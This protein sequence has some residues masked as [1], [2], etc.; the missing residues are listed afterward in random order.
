MLKR[1]KLSLA[2][3]TYPVWTYDENDMII[4]NDLPAEWSNDKQLDNAFMDISDMYDLQFIDNAV[5]FEY[6]GF[7][8][9]SLRESFISK[10]QKAVEMIKKKN[11]NKYVIQNNI[12]ISS[13]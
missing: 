9:D 2:Y 11:N 7:K 3:K 10:I 12:D 6:I 13:L 5:D 8:D 4:D 1:I